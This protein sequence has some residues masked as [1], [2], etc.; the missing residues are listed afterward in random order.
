MRI[1]IRCIQTR[2]FTTIALA[3]ER[4]LDFRLQAL[5]DRYEM[6]RRQTVLV[7]LVV[8]VAKWI[9]L[10]AIQLFL[11]L[12]ERAQQQIILLFKL[13]QFKGQFIL[14]FVAQLQCSL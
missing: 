10:A 5:R 6:Q 13:D 3:L 11:Q 12:V 7:G 14:T 2:E 9:V 4:R 8:Q 1:Q